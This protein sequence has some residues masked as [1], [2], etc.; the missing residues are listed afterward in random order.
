MDIF[1]R[2]ILDPQPE[3][4]R[5]MTCMTAMCGRSNVKVLRP[6]QCAVLDGKPCATCAEDIEL[7]KEM[8]K[9]EIR[10]EKILIRR[11]VL[12]TVMNEIHDRLIHRFPPEIGSHI[13]LQYALP[14]ELFNQDDGISP[15]YLGAVCWKWRQ[16]AWATPQ[17]WS[18][19]LV[20][21]CPR[22]RYNCSN[23]SDLLQLVAEW[24]E[25]SASLP[26]T[27]RFN[28]LIEEVHQG[29]SGVYRDVISIL[30]Q[31]SE[32]WYDMHFEL[33]AC[34]LHQLSGS[35]QGNML[36]RL[37]LFDRRPTRDCD[38]STFCM[39]SKPSPTDLT[40]VA[41]PLPY[42]DIIFDNLTVV[43]VDYIGIDECFELIRRAPVLETLSLSMIY[44]SSRFFP[45][46]NTRIILPHLRSLELSRMAEENVA[47]ILDS[48]CL[49]SLER[50]IHYQSQ[51]PL[52]NMISF[53]GRLSSRLKTFKITIDELN[54][55]QL[56][57]LLCPL[58]SLESLELRSFTHRS[59]GPLFDALSTSAQSPLF[60]PHLQSLEFGGR[61]S[62]PLWKCVLQIFALSHRQSLRV[63][64][65]GRFGYHYPFE[66]ETAKRL[67]ELV[68][69]G[70]DLSIG[71]DKIDL[72]QKYK[73]RNSAP[74]Q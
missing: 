44:A 64:I 32:R 36:R 4:D 56:P 68:D 25:R 65:N 54:Y 73:E 8:N 5:D 55:H 3:S 57:A 46:P 67:L 60:L 29:V 72:L 11:R 63:K 33:P 40:L 34:H 37:V 42:V 19:L 26:L 20:G 71:D 59:T 74:T 38:F 50:W 1:F 10:A 15:L 23:K 47:K 2:V 28:Y 43:T 22:G 66:D 31:H 45:I 58:S 17:L 24:L 21:F 53:I 70:F 39:K 16:L 18:S 48:A 13:F 49:P 30:N 27:I 9:L 41:V 61:I 69:R 35:P 12:R 62:S 14:S 51:F 6:E 52:E 7:E